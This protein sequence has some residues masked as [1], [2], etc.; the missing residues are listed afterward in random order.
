MPA[1]VS[2][3]AFFL[4]WAEVQGWQVP[5][6]HI[7]ACHWLEHRGRL[8]VLRCF[9]GFGKSTL[10]ACYNAWR[11]WQDRSYRILHQGDQDRTA[12]KTSRDTRAVL[13]RHPWTRDEFASGIRGEASFWWVP[14]S[15]DERNPSLQAAGITTNI[16]SSRTD[17]AQND[18]VEVPRNITN[19][20]M[21][22]KMR[23][24]LG[25]QTHCM[26]PG[27]RQLFV[28]TPH[29]HH[30]L[31]DE[32]AAMGADCLTIRMFADEHRIEH[33]TATDYPA[34]FVPDIVLAGIG[35][36]TRELERGKDWTLKDG[37]LRF[38]AAPGGL[39]DLYAGNSWPERFTHEEM[40]SRRRKCKTLNEWDSQYQLHSKPPQQVRLDPDRMVVYRDEPRFD[41]ANKS[42]RMWLGSARI[43]GAAARWDPSSAKPGSDVSALSLVFQDGEGRRYWHRAIRLEGDVA[44]FAPDGKRIMGGQVAQ[45]CDVVEQYKLRLVRVESNGV[46]V[47]APTILRAAL[48]QRQL[49][50]GVQAEPETRNKNKAILEAFEPLLSSA[51]ML[52]AHES[53]VDGPAYDEMRQWSPAV[54][55]QPDD[56]I[57]SAAKAIADQ[58]E[59]VGH[60]ARIREIPPGD[61]WRPGTGVYEAQLTV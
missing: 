35:A 15:R 22:D 33:A 39:V 60:S 9:R 53:V 36:Q 34:P 28:G 44:E 37:R 43:V 16:T 11:L 5:A 46:G 17:E 51:G 42:L 14:G 45:I 2:F 57:D 31:Y 56:Y 61:D 40:V 52:W 25:E 54:S 32:V 19:P 24:R 47:F 1:S 49:A 13:M 27:A 12:Y 48:K 50:C 10:L 59:R 26:V 23:Y 18:D 4:R 55:Q 30:S 21:R 7:E 38:R 20:E 29:T 3:L 6:I 8:A 41:T 58:P